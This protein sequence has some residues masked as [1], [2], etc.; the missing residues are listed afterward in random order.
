MRYFFL[1]LVALFLSGGVAVAHVS[2]EVFASKNMSAVKTTEL[3]S[4][5]LT[6]TNNSVEVDGVIF[7]TVVPNQVVSIP[8]NMPDIK[9]PWRVGI[10]I[11]NKTS[12]PI[13]FNKYHLTPEFIGFNDKALF[14]DDFALSLIPLTERDFPLVPPGK[15]FT[16]FWEGEFYWN[17]NRLLFGAYERSRG[18]SLSFGTFTPGTYDVRLTYENA[19][20]EISYVNL[21]NG[22]R[23]QLKG[24]VKG[25][26]STPWV[27]IK[28]VSS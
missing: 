14:M 18:R 15:S 4:V 25:L 13:R 27:E 10:R 2:P 7:E 3:T 8:E 5:Q 11:T 19:N 12:V 28:L 26:F 16:V 6:N 20:T 17:E 22:Q 21:K 9:T 24:I 1:F 23:R